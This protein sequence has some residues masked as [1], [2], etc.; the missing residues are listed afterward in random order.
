MPDWLKAVLVCVVLF[1]VFWFVLVKPT[2]D[3]VDMIHEYMGNNQGN[4]PTKWTG[5]TGNIRQN[6]QDIV[7]SLT[8]IQNDICVLQQRPNCPP[9]PATSPVKPPSYPP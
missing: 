6:N 7:K 3:R 4:D 9:G 5:L 1:F 2:K 8:T